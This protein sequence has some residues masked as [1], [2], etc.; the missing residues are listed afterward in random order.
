MT[1]E[2]EAYLKQLGLEQ[3]FK[4]LKASNPEALA[5]TVQHFTDKEAEN[6][7]RIV[8]SYFGERTI[9]RIADAITGSLLASPRLPSSARILDVG[10]GSGFFTAKIAGQIH[11][12]LPKTS[13]YA[14]DLTPAMLLSLAKKKAGITPFIGIAENIR[15][16]IRNARKF[17]K[18]PFNFDAAFSTLMLHHS[19]QPEKVLESLKAVLKKNGKAVL[20]DM[21][22][23][24]FEEFRTE[25]GDVHLGFKPK[26]IYEIASEYF[27][28][29]S[30]DV[31]PGIR[32]KSSGRS[33]EIF[34]AT[35]LSR[36]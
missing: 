23:H 29:V 7:D 4:E 9:N 10:A 25:M 31:M 36:P 21:C 19:T 6:R 13:F 3:L 27:P 11:A 34:I 8:A 14:M 32:C 17:L 26:K 35:M 30:V 20:V 18:I 16:S 2:I 1:A 15:G 28:A 24:G 22:E 12:K 33:A 5:N